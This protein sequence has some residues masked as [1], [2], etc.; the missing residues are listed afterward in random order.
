MGRCID[1]KNLVDD[2]FDYWHALD[3]AESDV[4]DEYFHAPDG[5]DSDVEEERSCLASHPDA[6]A[7]AI[8]ET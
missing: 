2:F 6:D 3:G 7:E 1:A 4:E 8:Q 5:A